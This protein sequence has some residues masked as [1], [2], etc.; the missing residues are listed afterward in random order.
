MFDL[1]PYYEVFPFRC[2]NQKCN[3]VFFREDFAQVAL[4]WGFIYLVGKEYKIIGV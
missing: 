3:E 4:L 1:K 2:K